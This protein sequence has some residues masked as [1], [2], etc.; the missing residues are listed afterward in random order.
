LEGAAQ[1]L[2]DAQVPNDTDAR[3]Q[4]LPVPV[5]ISDASAPSQVITQGAPTFD[6]PPIPDALGRG[7]R[8]EALLSGN[9][10]RNV[11]YSWTTD[12]QIAEL[13][14]N[15]DLL[16][17]SESSS[18][19]TTN[20]AAAVA[21]M[22]AAG[23]PLA[24]VLAGADFQKGRYAW[25]NA[26][27]T[28][29]G[30]PGESY[31][32]QLLRVVLKPEALIVAL[33]RGRA[34]VVD[35]NN[36]QVDTPTALANPERIGA[37]YF[38][39]EGM[40]GPDACGSFAKCP[41]GAYREYFINNEHMVQEWSIGTDA[42]RQEIERSITLVQALRDWLAGATAATEAQC[43][44]STSALCSWLNSDWPLAISV[45]TTAGEL[46]GSYQLG[47]ALTSEFYYPT[48]TNMDALLDELRASQLVSDPLVYK[49]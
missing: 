33:H 47:L 13:R 22:A 48:Q 3:S 40:A 7:L 6:G 45:P 20:L 29:R 23:E 27:A 34:S 30:W 46:L 5:P 16:T 26:W 41:S 8:D 15:P 12:A 17:R 1:D 11:L 10:A 14:A 37:V 2:A 35:L 19:G 18:H 42:I 44:F 28:R 49:P 4:A 43:S 9:V 36:Q 38:V 39:N 21:T 31:G 25:S 24:K 32:G